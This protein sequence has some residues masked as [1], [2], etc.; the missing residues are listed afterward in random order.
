MN[1]DERHLS[2]LDIKY[3]SSTLGR[4]PTEIE[5]SFIE[6]ILMKEL[7]SR[8]Y[9]QISKRLDDGAKREVNNK[10]RLDDKFNIFVH[11]GVK[12]V[13]QS[14]TV[15]VDKDETKYINKIENL[16]IVLDD[17]VINSSTY[18]NVEK[19]SKKEVNSRKDRD[20]IGGRFIKDDENEIIYYTSIGLDKI[21]DNSEISKLKDS[22]IC[23]IN[24]G[25]RSV[26]R[27]INQLEKIIDKINIEE[28]FLFAKSINWNGLGVTLI[29]LMKE[30]DHGINIKK[31]ITAET[32]SS[33]F[34][35]D[36]TLSILIVIQRDMLPKM[37]AF[38][39]KHELNFDEI[40][41]LS[42]EPIIHINNKNNTLINLSISAFDLQYNV[43]TKHFKQAEI[44]IKSSK[45]VSKR[46]KNTSFT[47][48]LLKLSTNITTD[49]VLWKN[50][51]RNNKLISNYSSYGLYSN[52]ES[53]E[54]QMVFTQA[55]KN[56][57][58]DAS[59]RLSGRVSVANA[60]R[61]LSCTGAKPKAVVI[62]NI[63][64]KTNNNSLWKASE[65]LQGQEEAIRELEVE[66]GNRLL[67]TYKN[68]WLQ[69]ISAIGIHQ[70]NSTKMDISFKHSGDFISLLGSHR[71]ELE[72]SA[73]QR[74]HRCE[75]KSCSDTKHIS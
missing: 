49:D 61:R 73:Y 11:N 53:I 59:P 25:K 5:I 10:I 24:L 62:Q 8:E 55:D 48:Q 41:K 72:G 71:G 54:D 28:W 74:L 47:T 23:K 68:Y 9:L 66:I 51:A 57:L 37:N 1:I 21:S 27:N 65:L 33:Q 36:K 4:F 20:V 12:I 15:T 32:L 14:N 13:D 56:Y 30:T 35:D 46:Y 22:I 44:A 26:Q 2:E 16:D 34:S 63:F 40:G 58:I 64:P 42:N 45:N 67:E 3:I 52:N 43:N 69:N 31:N 6:L 60:V 70:Q 50:A 75:T 19:I 7:L 29:N 38:C 39:K 18:Q 17:I